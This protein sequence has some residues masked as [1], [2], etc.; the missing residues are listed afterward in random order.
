MKDVR[1]DERVILKW[2]INK[3]GGD[4][5]ARFIWHRLGTSGRPLRTQKLTS[6]FYEVRRI[7]LVTVRLLASQEQRISL[8]LVLSPIFSKD[9]PFE[10]R[11]IVRR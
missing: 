11:A 6:E 5:S 7:S 4:M 3:H 1:V 8:Q 2:S 10:E 9:S